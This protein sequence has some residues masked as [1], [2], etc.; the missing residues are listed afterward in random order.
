MVS[1]RVS[2]RYGTIIAWYWSIQRR[3]LN[4]LNSG[5]SSAMV[6]NM[7]IDSTAPSTRALPRKRSRAS[8]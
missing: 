2:D 8:A 3:S 1:G 6:G 4:S 5:C 7:A